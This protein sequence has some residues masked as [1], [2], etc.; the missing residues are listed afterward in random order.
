MVLVCFALAEL[1]NPSCRAAALID[2]SQL[3]GTDARG[4]LHR[5]PSSTI[6]NSCADAIQGMTTTHPTL[7]AT[8]CSRGQANS[9][10]SQAAVP[11]LLLGR[12]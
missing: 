1:R 11:V 5:R 8:D 9:S 10:A 7:A 12:D 6:T 2:K 4:T 3:T